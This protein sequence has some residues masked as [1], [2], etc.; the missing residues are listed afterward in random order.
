M[1]RA[2]F[3]VPEISIETER[4]ARELRM[5]IPIDPTLDDSCCPNEQRDGN[6]GC[7]NCGAPSY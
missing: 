4:K 7:V 3:M 2:E 6:G 5:S 1:C